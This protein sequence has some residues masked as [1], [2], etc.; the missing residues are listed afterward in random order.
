MINRV[1][2]CTREN[3]FYGMQKLTSNAL[4]GSFIHCDYNGMP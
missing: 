4:D 2:Q 1:L 3:I